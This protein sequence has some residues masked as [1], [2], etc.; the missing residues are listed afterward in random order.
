[1][2]VHEEHESEYNKHESVC[3]KHDS[4]C[5]KHE[6]PSNKH[7]KPVIIQKYKNGDMETREGMYKNLMD[8][9]WSIGNEGT[10]FD[11][12]EVL[13]EVREFTLRYIR[14]I[15]YYSSIQF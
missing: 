8:I 15:S 5:N 7:K 10:N 6:L 12:E 11:D 13:E 2:H 1:M 3:N 4:C 14:I 9:L